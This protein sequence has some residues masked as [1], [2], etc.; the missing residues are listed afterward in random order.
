[1]LAGFA[2]REKY[3]PVLKAKLEEIEQWDSSVEKE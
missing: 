3:L 1:M 2:S